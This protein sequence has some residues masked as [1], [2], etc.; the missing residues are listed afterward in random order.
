[1]IHPDILLVVFIFLWVTQETFYVLS[2]NEL[3]YIYRWG[4]ILHSKGTYLGTPKNEVESKEKLFLD[5]LDQLKI[6]Y[7]V[8][9]KLNKL[10]HFIALC[11][12]QQHDIKHIAMMKEV[13]HVFPD[14]RWE[15]EKCTL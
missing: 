2:E 10:I 1:M 15:K 3:K 13:I 11:T 14:V 7:K 9:A 8:E 4:V 12:C 6:P 5:H